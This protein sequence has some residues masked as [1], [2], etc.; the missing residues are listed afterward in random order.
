MN[1]VK[2]SFIIPTYLTMSFSIGLPAIL[3]FANLIKPY[4]FDD[5]DIQITIIIHSINVC[6]LY[7]NL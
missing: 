7:L 5:I 6:V 4:N 1:G 3:S 2:P